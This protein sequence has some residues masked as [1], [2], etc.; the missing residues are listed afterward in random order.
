MQPQPSVDVIGIVLFRL[1]GLQMNLR[2]I[3]A[4]KLL[5]KLWEIDGLQ[6]FPKV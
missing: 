3:C 1:L 4:A 5:V 6:L 2:K